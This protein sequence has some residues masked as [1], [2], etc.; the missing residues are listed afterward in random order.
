MKTETFFIVSA[1][2]A[3]ENGVLEASKQYFMK[4]SSKVEILSTNFW[5]IWWASKKGSTS[6]ATNVL[7]MIQNLIATT[8]PL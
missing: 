7:Q 2:L 3:Y 6:D 4:A 1:L 8:K 5:Q